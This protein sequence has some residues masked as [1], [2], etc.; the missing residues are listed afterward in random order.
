MERVERMHWHLLI[1]RMWSPDTA[2]LA[3][4]P[5]PEGVSAKDKARFAKQRAQAQRAIE[6]FF[7]P[8]EE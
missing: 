3:N 8:D 6:T 4:S 2:A 1:E 7:P 5:T